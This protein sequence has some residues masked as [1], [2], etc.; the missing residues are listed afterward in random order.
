MLQIYIL[1]WCLC[2]F[3]D[4]ILSKCQLLVAGITCFLPRLVIK[5]ISGSQS[6]GYRMNH[7]VGEV[8]LFIALWISG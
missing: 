6:A 2:Y 8:F 4:K 5:K 1:I 3:E 7:F